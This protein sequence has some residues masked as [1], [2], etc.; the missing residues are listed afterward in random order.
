MCVVDQHS[1]SAPEFVQARSVLCV[2]LPSA[3]KMR[4]DACGVAA[5]YILNVWVMGC[6]HGSLLEAY[7]VMACGTTLPV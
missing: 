6:R 1:C 7:I 4:A 2:S 5:G 3:K